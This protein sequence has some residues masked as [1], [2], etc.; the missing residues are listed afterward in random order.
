MKLIKNLSVL[1]LVAIMTFVLVGCMKKED[2]YTK[3]DVNALVEE[4]EA[5]LATKSG[6]L[7]KAIE[8]LLSKH[9]HTYGEWVDFSGNEN[10]YCENRL[11][12]RICQEC[13]VLEWK[14]GSYDNHHF[15]TVTTKPTC[16]AGG[17]DTKTCSTCG[18]VEITNETPKLEHPWKTEYTYDNT[19]HWVECGYC[20]EKKDNVEHSLGDDGICTGC[21]AV[22]GATD[23]ILYE[24]SADG[25]Y[26][27]VVGYEGSAKRVK[28]AEEYQGKPVKEIYKDA[29]TF[30]DIISVIIPDSVT[31]IG[32]YAFSGCSSLTSITVDKNN[33]AYKDID[34]NLYTKDGKTLLQYA[35]GKTDVHFT[36]PNNVSD[37]GDFAFYECPTLTS[38]TIPD[39]VTSIGDYAFMN[40]SSL[41]NINYR[42]TKKQWNAIPKVY[43]WDYNTGYYTITYNYTED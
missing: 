31:S 34:G 15:V 14:S 24:L 28:I 35:I 12:Y 20:G 17:Y 42:G 18:K 26:A 5:A 1:L 6:E 9:E 22:V 30:T 43:F 10:V 27:T 13:K 41:K 36:I 3:D 37:I 23:G 7:N 38:V 25:T 29:F 40:C 19:F 33:T 4:L 16:Q 11:F 32:D 2:Y 8:A 39:S 21:D